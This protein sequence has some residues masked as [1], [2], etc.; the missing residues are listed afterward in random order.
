MSGWIE[1][2]VQGGAAAAIR[3]AEVGKQHI[4]YSVDASF[5]TTASDVLQIKD[6]TTVIWQGHVYDTREVTFPK[7]FGGSKGALVTAELGAGA[8]NASV[9]LHGETF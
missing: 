7:G 9:N 1:T 6:G 3:A 2:D 8:G 5:S 4:I